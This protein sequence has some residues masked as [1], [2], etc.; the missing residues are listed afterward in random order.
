MNKF[1]CALLAPFFITAAVG[2]ENVLV[3]G[4][5]HSVGSFGSAF[6]KALGKHR[7]GTNVVLEASWGS[8]PNDWMQGKGG[9]HYLHRGVDGVRTQKPA[10]SIPTM[11]SLM[12]KH[13]PAMTVIALGSNLYK[14]SAQW[15]RQTVEQMEAQATA[16]GGPCIWVGPPDMRERGGEDAKE[17]V[18]TIRATLKKC[19][20]IDSLPLTSYPAKGGDGIH[21]DYLG[22]EGI[23]KTASWA[24]EVS[25]KTNAIMDEQLRPCDGEAIGLPGI[26]SEPAEL[27]KKINEIQ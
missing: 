6:Y 3:L 15:I 21:Y 2:A 19:T 20:F 24:Y 1:L 25:K 23:K 18:K 13:K 17:L 9:P 5:S 14:A 26:P 11:K 22:G 8:S 4:D 16:S 7:P 10:G 27:S 12:D